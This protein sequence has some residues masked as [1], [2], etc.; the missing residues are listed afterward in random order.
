MAYIYTV[1]WIAPQADSSNQLAGSTFSLDQT[2]DN[3][4][5]ELCWVF[6]D[7]FLGN[8]VLQ[9]RPSVG[10]GETSTTIQ[11][12]FPIFD[13]FLPWTFSSDYPSQWPLSLKNYNG[14]TYCFVRRK[15]MPSANATTWCF[16]QWVRTDWKDWQTLGPLLGSHC[17]NVSLPLQVIKIMLSGHEIVT[18][19]ILHPSKH[20]NIA[21]CVPV[22]LQMFFQLHC[23]GFPFPLTHVGVYTQSI[24]QVWGESVIASTS[25]VPLVPMHQS[26]ATHSELM[27]RRPMWGQTVWILPLYRLV[28]RGH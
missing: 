18:L 23:L 8:T 25:C 14:K 22:A 24:S 27:W 11:A 17:R 10:W 1:L 9:P 3:G 13:N 26:A 5:W 7:W 4:R 15:A 21:D 19:L 6:Y 20:I 2:G 28:S 16:G 12:W